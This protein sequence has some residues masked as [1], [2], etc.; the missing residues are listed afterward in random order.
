VLILCLSFESIK[1]AERY[2]DDAIIKNKMLW[3]YNNITYFSY[4]ENA[5]IGVALA[6]YCNKTQIDPLENLTFVTYRQH[7]LDLAIF[8][9]L[10][11]LIIWDNATGCI[12]FINRFII[13]HLIQSSLINIAYSLIS[14]VINICL[15]ISIWSICLGAS[16]KRIYIDLI[17]K[18]PYNVR[19]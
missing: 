2:H 6:S 4:I 8:L 15:W 13:T 12:D 17:L 7:M 3:K 19:Q 10:H 5:F 1:S 11:S 18:E 14:K 16:V 9:K